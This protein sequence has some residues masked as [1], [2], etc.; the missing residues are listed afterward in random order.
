MISSIFRGYVE[1]RRQHPTR[2]HLCY[3]LYVYALDLAELDRLDRRLPL[4]GY[5][6]WRPVSLRDGD[7]LEESN[8]GLREKL[9]GFVAPRIP[10]ERIDRILMVTACR[11]MGYI[12]NPVSLYYLYDPDERLLGNVAEVNNT[13]GERHVYVLGPRNGETPV[14]PARYQAAKAF[15][16]S[17]F[18]TV[19]G[20]YH[21]SFADIRREL[22]IRIDLHHDQRTILEARLKGEPMALTPRNHLKT[23]LRHPLTPHLTIPRIYQEAFKLRFQRKL[24]YYPK[25]VAR[26][27]MTIRRN[28]PTALQRRS[29]DLVLNYLKRTSRGSLRLSLPNGKTFTYGDRETPKAH[30]RVNDYR[31][32]SRVVLGAD[33]GFGE[34]F[35]EDEWDS[36][37]PT[38]VVRFF[39][40]NRNTV[41]DGRFQTT[42][43]SR[44]LEWLRHLAQHNSLTGSRRNIRRHYDLS[45]DFFQTF[46]DESMAYSCAVYPSAQASLE[47]AQQNKYT[48]I[49]HKARLRATDHVLEIGCGWGGFAIAAVRQTGCRYTGITVS[50]EQFHLARA[51]VKAAGLEDRIRI[52]FQD[53]RKIRGQFDKIVSIEMLEAVGHAYF[54]TFFRA[55]ERLLKPDGIAVVQVISIPDQHYDRYRKER[56]WIQKHI[57][58]GGLLPSLTILATTMTRHSRLMIDHAENIGDHYALTLAEWRRRFQAARETVAGLGFDR[59]FRRKWV[60]YLSSCE[61]GFREKVLG[62]LQLVL[63]REGNANL[64]QF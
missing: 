53:Y 28:P 40:Q 21:F 29:I 14:Y 36:D 56:D 44:G 43:I 18:N 42:V 35:M 22:D 15:H 63:T 52:E 27:T 7:Y 59:R 62:N 39:I 30:L 20:Q 3:P 24:T 58:P 25:P 45:N 4:F 19:E 2:H 1:H 9:L 57:F 8:R 34:A 13:F 64:W 48:R 49:I 38:A 5:N 60:Y 16:V 51:R 33:I 17:P 37:D 46:L 55:L 23:V 32:F 12:F 26:S 47:D 54:S 61:A 11:Y 41:K 10:V 31:F 50:R 6:R